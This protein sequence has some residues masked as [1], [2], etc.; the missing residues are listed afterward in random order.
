MKDKISVTEIFVL[1]N[2]FSANATKTEV[3]DLGGKGTICDEHAKFPVATSAAV[4]ALMEDK[5]PLICGGTSSESDCYFFKNQIWNKTNE[6]T[7]VKR[8]YSASVIGPH[9]NLWITGGEGEGEE[10]SNTSEYITLN[11]DSGS[12]KTIK[13]PELNMGGEYL[14]LFHIKNSNLITYWLIN[15]SINMTKVPIL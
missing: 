9:G 4:G 13:G 2:F 3:I 1:F 10:A 8:V 5:W 15:N 6:K 11:A 14:P 12:I 7:I